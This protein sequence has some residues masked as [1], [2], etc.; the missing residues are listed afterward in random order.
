[1]P[2]LLTPYEKAT[3]HKAVTLLATACDRLGNVKVHG[4]AQAHLLNDIYI[5]MRHALETLADISPNDLS[6]QLRQQLYRQDFET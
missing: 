1:M 4:W 5:T 3:Y 2:T 6:R